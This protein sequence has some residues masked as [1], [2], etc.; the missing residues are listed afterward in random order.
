MPRIAAAAAEAASVRFAPDPGDDPTLTARYAVRIDSPVGA[1]AVPVIICY[2]DATRATFHGKAKVMG[3]VSRFDGRRD[4]ALH[5]FGVSVRLPFGVLDVRLE[6]SVAADG[7]VTGHAI[8]P[9]RRPMVLTGR[10]TDAC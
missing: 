2:D 7:S 10:R 6:A 8:A 1:I 3:R 4:G 9:N 5:A